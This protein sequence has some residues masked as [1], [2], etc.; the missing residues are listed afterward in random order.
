ML[1]V[2]LAPEVD[3]TAYELSRLNFVLLPLKFWSG[4]HIPH[5]PYQEVL[6]YFSPDLHRHIKIYDVAYEIPF[7]GLG[8]GR[9]NYVATQVYPSPK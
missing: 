8:E 5:A 1:R 6:D 9:K 7:F 4:G 2:D 3:I